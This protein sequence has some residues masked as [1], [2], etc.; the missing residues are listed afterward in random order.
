MSNYIGRSQSEQ[1]LS[2]A[3]INRFRELV[4]AIGISSSNLKRFHPQDP[5]E[6]RCL[7]EIS[8]KRA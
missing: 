5:S 7:A 8:H 4:A 2:Q 1:S 6:E 3:E